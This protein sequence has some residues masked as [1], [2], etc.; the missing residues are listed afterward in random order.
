M[1]LVFII[2]AYNAK[3]KESNDM[4]NKIDKILGEL[5]R[6]EINE[7]QAVDAL[8]S[9][10]NVVTRFAVF[11][12]INDVHTQLSIIDYEKIEEAQ[13]F[14]DAMADTIRYCESHI[15]ILNV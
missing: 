7:S 11:E 1:A 10:F 14:A 15:V 12:K 5:V 8:F 2:M 13:D 3:N 9:L 6:K 4:R